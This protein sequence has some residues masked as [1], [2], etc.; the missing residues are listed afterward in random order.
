MIYSIALLIH[1]WHIVISFH[2]VFNKNGRHAISVYFHER[3][4][5]SRNF[6]FVTIP[7]PGTFEKHWDIAFRQKWCFS[8]FQYWRLSM[9]WS[10]NF[11]HSKTKC[12]VMS[13]FKT[14]TSKL[15]LI[16]CISHFCFWCNT[17]LVNEIN[18]KMTYARPAKN[19]AHCPHVAGKSFLSCKKY[20]KRLTSDK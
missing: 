2:D 5:T 16:N 1:R 3:D 10:L 9:N 12:V 18:C 20:C 19:A 11:Q 15:Y 6:D 4:L 14:G 17:R 13:Y 7:S 8:V